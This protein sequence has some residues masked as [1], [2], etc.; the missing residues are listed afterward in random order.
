MTDTP[1]ARNVLWHV[2]KRSSDLFWTVWRRLPLP[3]SARRQGIDFLFRHLSPLVAWTASYRI[4]KAEQDRIAAQI[5]RLAEF[6]ELAGTASAGLRARYEDPSALPRPDRLLARAIAFYLPQFHAIPE[7]DEWWGTG[8]TEWTNVRRARPQFQGHRQPRRPAELGYYDLMAGS[9]TR[10]R[11]A[12]LAHQ[13]GIEAF[14]F[15]F[16]WFGGRRLLEGPTKAYAE[17]E[18]ITFPFCLCWANESWSRRWDGREDQKLVA[19]YHSP[20]DDIAFISHIADYLRSDKYLRVDGKPL[21]MV[22]RPDLLP[23]PKATT[24]RWRDWCRSHGIG[25]IHLAYTLS[26]V[27]GT[28]DEY[29]FDTAIEFAPNNM[30][31]TQ[32]EDLVQPT[33]DNFAARIYDLRELA[34]RSETYS[35]PGHK[36][37]RGVTP[38]WDNTARRMNQ[39]AVMLDGGPDVYERWLRNAAR[40][41]APNQKNPSERLVAINAWNEWAEGAYLEP[42]QDHGYAWLAATRRALAAEPDKLVE[43]A[44]LVPA[45][46]MLSAPPARKVLLVIHDLHR[47]GAQIHTLH[48]AATYR[49][50]F[51]CEV[52]TIACG[53]GPLGPNFECYGRLIHLPRKAAGESAVRRTIEQLYA[54]GYRTAVIN[55][56]ASGWLTPYLSDAGINCVGLVHELPDIIRTMNIEQDIEAFDAHARKVVFASDMVRNRTADEIL[57]RP[58]SN[59]VILPQGH[60]KAESLLNPDEKTAAAAALRT[61]MG[62][63]DDAQF[64]IGVGYGDFRKGVD[65]F[66]RWAVEAARRNPHWH[67]VWVGNLGAE[68]RVACHALLANAGDIAGNVHFAGFQDDTGAFYR[69]ASA[70]ALTSREDPFP[71]TVLE[72]LA[73]GAPVFCVDGTT[74]FADMADGACLTALPDAEAATFADALEGLLGSEARQRQASEA[75]IALVQEKFGFC[76]FAGDLLRLAG[77]ELPRISVVI[78]NYNYARF[79]PHRIATILAQELPVWEIIFLDDASTDDSLEVAA[80]LLK[81]C[82]IRYRI[83]PNAENS[84]SVFAQW[85]KGADLAEGDIVWIAEADDWASARFTRV[86][87]AAFADPETVVSYTQSNQVSQDSEIL[88]P[89]Y[90]DYVADIDRERWRRPFVNAG[91]AELNDGLAVKNT[92]PNVSGVLFR[93]EAL[94]ATL[95]QHMDEIRSYRVAG[96]WC[97]YAHLAACGKF[98]FDPRPLNYH[99]RH[100]DSVTISR[101]TQAEWDEIARMQARVQELADVSG[102]MAEKA[103][104]YLDELKKRL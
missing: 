65:I 71:T 31:L 3:D 23:D 42:D 8:F 6:R 89:H 81:D 98:A 48:M 83:V 74:G 91:Q 55:S 27:N 16:Y 73:C 88:C 95:E 24:R 94:V 103:A 99:R 36:L 12:A 76:S 64:I 58:W 37:A 61:R 35:R 46:P 102:S 28:P 33:G 78:P 14:C 68:E 84:G 50:R 41:M 56:S 69:A 32:Q 29:G 1:P 21:V 63:P 66:V 18:E 2:R 57:G 52:T 86:A 85:K 79:L 4:W 17:D 59:A 5:A 70:Y 7:N 82:G 51:G 53:D 87:A 44:D 11:Q 45:E 75:G 9:T 15:Y 90:L 60:Y 30:N 20:E 40:D 80:Q 34:A 22:Y 100:A 92:L 19:Q 96:D 77:E 49:E 101:F 13:Y 93:R 67:F 104:A 62:L 25:D 54:D 26:F 43:P 38:Q 10:R 47:N 72:A 39:A 97:A